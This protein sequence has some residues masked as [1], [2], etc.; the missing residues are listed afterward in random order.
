MAGYALGLCGRPS[1]RDHFSEDSSSWMVLPPYPQYPGSSPSTGIPAMA[2]SLVGVPS[3]GHGMADY[4]L[5]S[6]LQQRRSPLSSAAYTHSWSVSN[7]GIHPQL[8]NPPLPSFF[9]S[10]SSSSFLI[11]LSF[12]HRLVASFNR[13]ADGFASG[14]TPHLSRNSSASDGLRCKC[15]SAARQFEMS[16]MKRPESGRIGYRFILSPLP[17]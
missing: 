15:Q 3:V 2:G 1:L 13:P 12:Q 10:S 11:W 7:S 14:L 6:S 16:E 8:P 17:P 4:A 5:A 9:S